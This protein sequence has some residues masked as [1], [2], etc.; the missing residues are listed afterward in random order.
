M[1]ASAGSSP[2]AQL[3]LRAPRR[4][5]GRPPSSA[6]RAGR[7]GR[8]RRAGGCRRSACR[9]ADRRAPGFAS[10][11][12]QRV[13]QRRRAPRAG[14]RACAHALDH[15][16][17]HP[18]LQIEQ[19]RFLAGVVEVEA[20]ARRAGAAGDLRRC[21]PPRRRRGGTRRARRAKSCSRVRTPFGPRSARCGARP[22][23]RHDLV[24]HR[25]DICQ[26]KLADVNSGPTD[27]TGSV[28]SV[29]SR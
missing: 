5:A 24:R 27:V 25:P 21:S 12:D 1:V 13:D 7:R 2:R 22:V 28:T 6:G 17:L 14:V 4:S 10:H 20:G 29:G 9:A 23:G 19:H 11:G 16:D 18:P 26:K 8:A 3:A 15:L